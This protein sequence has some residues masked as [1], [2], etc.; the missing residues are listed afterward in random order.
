MS[1][2]HLLGTL[3]PLQEDIPTGL[4]VPMVK[5]TSPRQRVKG[6][7]DNGSHDPDSEVTHCQ[8]IQ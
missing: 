7:H 6:R 4:D 3:N 8:S 1:G 2:S 5:L